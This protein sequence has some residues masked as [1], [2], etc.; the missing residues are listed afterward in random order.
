MA[1]GVTVTDG[2]SPDA[3]GRRHSRLEPRRTRERVTVRTTDE[4]L[5]AIESLV[6][7]DVYPNR[8]EAIRAGIDAVIER[9]D[10]EPQSDRTE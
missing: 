9:H 8:S 6:T 10:R 2:S 3:D 1:P 7:A 5:E 4:Q